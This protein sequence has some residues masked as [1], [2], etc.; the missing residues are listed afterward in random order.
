MTREEI[1]QAALDATKNRKRCGLSLATGTGKT[2]VGLMHMEKNMTPL[3][4]VL[5]QSISCQ[6][7]L[8]LVYSNLSK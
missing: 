6:T 8:G 3:M 7:L 1:Q 5:H 4:N 2:L